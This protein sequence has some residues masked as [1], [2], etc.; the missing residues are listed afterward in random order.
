[1]SK[2]TKFETQ[3]AELDL[4]DLSI[5]SGGVNNPYGG[6]VYKFPD[7]CPHCGAPLLKKR[8]AKKLTCNECG[9]EI[10]SLM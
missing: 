9:A 10:E 7:N 1:M 6:N 5:V 4:D 2:K 8:N 3:D